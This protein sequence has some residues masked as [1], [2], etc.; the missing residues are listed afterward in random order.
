MDVQG[1]FCVYD[2]KVEGYL[3]P[4]SAVNRAVAIRQFE[5]AVLDE[6]TEFHKH[7]DDFSLWYVGSFDPNT[8]EVKSMPMG[9]VINAHQ[10]L[11]KREELSGVL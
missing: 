9:S 3:P 7:A 8:G 5:S 1:L 2:S 4:W 6:G 10:I 11:A